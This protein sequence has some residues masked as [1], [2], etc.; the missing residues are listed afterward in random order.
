MQESKMR[1][2]MI[3]FFSIATLAAASL[4]KAQEARSATRDEIEYRINIIA[5]EVC[6]SQQAQ[7][8]IKK[9]KTSNPKDPRAGIAILE[10][11]FAEITLENPVPKPDPTVLD[12]LCQDK[13]S[14]LTKWDDTYWSAFKEGYKSELRR[15]LL[16]GWKKTGLGKE[17]QIMMTLTQTPQNY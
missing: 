8:E 5:A 9:I 13:F 12:K 11:K 16:E 14:D 3:L 7:A 4:V 1:P 2:K 10:Q 15:H 17:Q 6:A